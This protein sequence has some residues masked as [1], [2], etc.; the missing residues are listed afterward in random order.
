M[1]QADDQD[2]EQSESRA[3]IQRELESINHLQS[4]PNLEETLLAEREISEKQLFLMFQNSASAISQLYKDRYE[5]AWLPFQN[6]ALAVTNLYKECLNRLQHCVELGQQTGRYNRTKD[7]V[8]WARKRR[9]QI[10]REDLLAYLCGVPIPPRNRYNSQSGRRLSLERSLP[11]PRHSHSLSHHNLAGADMLDGDLNRFEEALTLQGISGMS[12][13]S[14][15][16][17]GH[18]ASTQPMENLEDFALYR[19]HRKRSTQ[20]HDVHDSPARKRSRF[21]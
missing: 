16:F 17:H 18:S 2:Q 5:V 4:Q 3:L 15:G 12:G 1:H 6:A 14:S 11:V 10:Q 19:D 9:R 13:R 20:P 8:A 7:L 21:L